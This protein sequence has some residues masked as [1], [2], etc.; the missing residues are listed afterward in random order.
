[1]EGSATLFR[2]PAWSPL[3]EPIPERG[4]ELVVS[5]GQ[6]R[7]A[8]LPLSGMRKA[9][10]QSMCEVAACSL[11]AASV[12]DHDGLWETCGVAMR[13]QLGQRRGYL[14]VTAIDGVQIAL[15]GGI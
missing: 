14:S 7:T 15:R 3:R 5:Q 6:G 12:L 9:A 13:R 1:M 4:S 10:V 8:G 2:L 11:R